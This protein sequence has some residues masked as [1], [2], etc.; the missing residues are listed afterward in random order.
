MS[1]PRLRL[2]SVNDER[3]IAQGGSKDLDGGSRNTAAIMLARP[4][5]GRASLGGSGS[6]RRPGSG[7]CRLLPAPG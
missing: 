2:Q 3:G 6:R 1:S 7:R 4:R 5:E